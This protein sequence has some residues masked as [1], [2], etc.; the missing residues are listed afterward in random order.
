MQTPRLSLLSIQAPTMSLSRQSPALLLGLIAV[1]FLIR[2]SYAFGAGNIAGI[3]SVE[4]QNCAHPLLHLH[5]VCMGD[6]ASS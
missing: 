4:G 6:H 1:F 3:S 2:P 5:S